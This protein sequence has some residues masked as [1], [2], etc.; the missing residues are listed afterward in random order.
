MSTPDVSGAAVDRPW[1]KNY[2]EGVPPSLSYPD[3]PLHQFLHDSAD[4]FPNN[5]A[6][7]FFGRRWTYRM[8]RQQ[9]REF[10][11]GLSRL[12]VTKGD[13]V[14]LVMPNSPQGIM[15][16]FA[17]LELGAT[18][19]Q[20]S[21]LASARDI[22]VQLRDSGTRIMVTLDVVAKP[23]W[24]L[25][26]EDG[27]L[28]HMIVGRLADALPVPLKWLFPIKARRDGQSLDIPSRRAVLLWSEVVRNAPEPPPVEVDPREDLASIL[29]TGGTTGTPKGVML[30]HR[31][32]VANAVQ[33]TAWFE[34]VQKGKERVLCVLPFFHVYGLTV[35]QNFGIANAATLIVLPKF[36]TEEVLKVIQ[37]YRPTVFPGIPTIYVA[38]NNHPRVA[39]YDLRSI[40]ACIS[41]AAPLPREVQQRFEELTGGKLVEGYGLTEASP[42]THAGP[43]FG[44]RKTGSIG[45]PLPDTDC[46]I[47]DVDTGEALPAGKAGELVVR[48]PQ[49]MKGYWNQPEETAKVLRDGW[50]HT[51]D[52]AVMD[53]DGYFYIVDRLKE[54]MIVGGYNVYPREIEEALYEHEDVL[55]AAVIS[56]TDEYLGETIKAYVVLREG[57][58]VTEDE[59]KQHCRERLARYKVPR[60]FEF[61]D[62]LPKSMVGKILRRILKEEE[63]A[64]VEGQP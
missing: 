16:Y 3:Q 25:L 42:V 10:A 43:L 21:P 30:T 53:E 31:N 9:V 41:G 7:L 47:V 35:C 48:G 49:V 17:V 44:K 58:T 4:Q 14:A 45:L 59:L 46:R 38:L 1:L 32:L 36:E 61:R 62:E 33:T 54:M 24:R 50:L 6:I 52:V 55:E 20:L 28:D 26:D 40:T 15:A 22:A 19:V 29:Y 8:L 56:V 51:G 27:L 12:G 57:A 60:I 2:P 11:G 23:F 37:K 5:D 13:R 64:K 63:M 34:G 18:V 39:Q